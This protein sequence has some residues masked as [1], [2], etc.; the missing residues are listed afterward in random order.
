M[1]NTSKTSFKAWDWKRGQQHSNTQRGV[2]IGHLAPKTR[3]LTPGEK[4]VR[5]VQMERTA[6]GSVD[7]PNSRPEVKARIL[8]VPF[9]SPLKGSK[10]WYKERKSLAEEMAE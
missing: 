8:A 9:Q 4:Y 2:P 5:A 1:A 10:P 7:D 3:D 6:S